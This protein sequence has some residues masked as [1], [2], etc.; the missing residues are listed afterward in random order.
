M[1]VGKRIGAVLIAVATLGLSAC[2]QFPGVN[3]PLKPV[4]QHEFDTP[5]AIPPLAESRVEDGVRI[6]ELDAQDG[7]RDFAPATEGVMTPTRGF[8]GDFLGPTLRAARGEQVAVEI[9]NHLDEATSVHWHGMHLPAAMDGGPHQEIPAGGAWWPEWQIDQP[10]ATL[11]YHPHPHGATEEHVYSGLAG[12]FIIDDDAS[13]RAD[14]PNDYGIDDIPVIVQDRAFAD[15]GSF[16][17]ARDGAEPGQLGQTILT[18]G[19]VGAYHEVTTERVRLR[20]LNG[21]TART[22]QF[23]APDAPMTVI[24]GD[25]GFLDEPVTPQ[26]PLRL[27]PGERA[28]VVVELRPGQTVRVRSEEVDLGGVAV[29]GVMGGGDAFDVMELRAAQELTP[30][31]EATWP[32]SVHGEEDELHESEAARTRSFKLAGREING[33]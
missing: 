12:M 33:E 29:P 7:E 13:E 26:D 11:W 31:P 32:Q 8:N 30:S 15:D 24:A 14:I 18:N 21:S 4:Q 16:L 1:N 22:Y 25:G 20:L 23:S 27:A 2:G 6:F 17:L 5:L 19:T 28:E 10:A 9:D 3:T